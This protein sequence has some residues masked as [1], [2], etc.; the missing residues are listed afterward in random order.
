MTGTNE[1]DWMSREQDL[2]LSDLEGTWK[3]P[4]IIL[5]HEVSG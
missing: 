5:I 1:L 4:W 3:G 2:K